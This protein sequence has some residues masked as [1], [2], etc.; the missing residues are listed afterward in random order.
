M[1]PNQELAEQIIVEILRQSKDGLNKVQLYKTFWVSHLYYSNENRGYLS[2][3]PVVKMPQGPGIDR[4]SHLL[5]KLRNQG[6]ITITQQQSGPFT[7]HLCRVAISAK[8]GSLSKEAVEAIGKA[9]EFTAKKTGS[10]LSQLS[11]EQS[12]GWRELGLG[13]E[14]DIYADCFT[15]EEI[16]RS[17]HEV[18][19]AKEQYQGLF[20]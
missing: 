6:E 13:E 3:W 7:E 15:D 4:A 2:N 14:I 16:T 8:F 17:R 12:R 20:E 5:E 19:L 1:T 18:A 11:H 10:Y 9:V